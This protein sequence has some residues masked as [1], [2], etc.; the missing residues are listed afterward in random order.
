[1]CERFHL[2]CCVA[3]AAATAV[4]LYLEIH[5]SFSPRGS[6]SPSPPSTTLAATRPKAAAGSE[7]HLPLV[8]LCLLAGA[9]VCLSG[10]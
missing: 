9:A 2:R 1:M 10:Q 4:L 7:A 3:A 6:S 8:S 5:T